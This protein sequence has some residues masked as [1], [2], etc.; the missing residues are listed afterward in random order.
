MKK[1]LAFMLA[2]LMLMLAS[3]QIAPAPADETT[4]KPDNTSEPT[5]TTDPA[6]PITL[7]STFS[8]FDTDLMRFIETSESGDYMASP[9][10]FLYAIGML[11]EGADE[12]TLAELQ[13]ALGIKDN[14]EFQKYIESVNAL[15]K[16]FNDTVA[17]QLET[18]NKLPENQKQYSTKP[19][20]ILRVANSVWKNEEYE[21]FLSQYKESLKL[22]EA[23]YR[24][25]NKNDVVPEVNK[26]VN[27]KT[28]GMIP[29]L[30]PDDYDAEKL[31]TI[32]MNALYYKNNWNMEFAKIGEKDFTTADGSKVKKEFISTAGHFYYYKDDVTEICVA[33]M[34]NGA[35]AVFV[36]G[37]MT[38]IEEKLAKASSASY[39]NIQVPIF[40]IESSFDNGEFVEFLKNL[41]VSDVFDKENANLGKMLDLTKIDGNLCVNDIIQKTKIKLDETGVEAA[42][43]TAIMVV[44]AT[45][46]GP[47]P[48]PIRFIADKPFH[49][50]IR[51]STDSY[52]DA[53]GITLF[54]GR[55]TK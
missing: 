43:V 8:T 46:A 2:V 44:E 10:S 20:G 18:Y 53:S 47:K 7:P 48:E 39:V 54:E 26:W 9:L 23:E 21:D 31:A 40:E 51:L 33:P 37:D 32:L 1:I 34:A 4:E 28:E 35:K 14:E 15:I 5:V 36:L 42:A 11:I 49:F 19:G 16:K 45:S 17:R 50:F 3:C 29:R 25:F 22:Y 13:T 12:N 30:L 41:G 52:W 24:D 38:G 6:G 55:L 27:E